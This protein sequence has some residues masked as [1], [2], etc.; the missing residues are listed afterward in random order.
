MVSRR[1]IVV[2]GILF[3]PLYNIS[4]TLKRLS[5]NE[6]RSPEMEAALVHSAFA[7]LALQVYWQHRQYHTYYSPAVAYLIREYGTPSLLQES[8]GRAAE[9]YRTATRRQ[10]PPGE[11]A[12]PVRFYS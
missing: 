4:R 7:T 10:A 2:D 8:R 11:I 12:G 5:C 9:M 1:F 3:E 6:E